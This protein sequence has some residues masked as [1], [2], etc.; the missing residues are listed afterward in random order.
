MPISEILS[1]KIEMVYVQLEILEDWGFT[2][3]MWARKA[4]FQMKQCWRKPLTVILPSISFERQVVRNAG[5][6]ARDLCR[7]NPFSSLHPP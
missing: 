2:E 3:G 4:Y 1:H 5:L 7:R 6:P